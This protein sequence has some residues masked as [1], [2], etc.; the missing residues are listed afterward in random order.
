[1]VRPIVIGVLVMIGAGFMIIDG[2][3][4]LSGAGYIAPGGE[5]GQWA[6]LLKRLGIDPHAPGVAMVFVG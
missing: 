4:E 3:R 6:G 5:L 1:M 2:V